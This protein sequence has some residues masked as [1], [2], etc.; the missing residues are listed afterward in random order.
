MSTPSPTH[1]RLRKTPS[2]ADSKDCLND[3]DFL[4]DFLSTSEE[5]SDLFQIPQPSTNRYI[6]DETGSSTQASTQVT[7]NCKR[8][9]CLKLYCDCF[10]QGFTCGPFCK[11][12]NCSNLPGFESIITKSRKSIMKRNPTAFD[13]KIIHGNRHSRGCKC[14]SS[15][16]IKK[17]CEC[18]ASNVD[19]TEYCEC[20]DCKNGKNVSYTTDDIIQNS[21]ILAF[22]NS[23]ETP[24][25]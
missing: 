15:K 17:Y 5:S 8:S 23:L 25:H 11:C 12:E 20:C 19:C 3:R 18:F 13:K 16:C 2:S 21:E 4:N 1:K 10:S 14:K 9:K 6:H 7:C 22:V 24:I